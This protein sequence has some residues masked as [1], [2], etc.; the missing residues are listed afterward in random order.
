LVDL[1]RDSVP[2]RWKLLTKARENLLCAED[3]T[4]HQWHNAST[5]R[6]YYAVYQAGKEFVEAKGETRAKGWWEHVD[7]ANTVSLLTRGQQGSI[8]NQMRHLRELADYERVLLQ[9]GQ[10]SNEFRRAW[11]FLNFV[12]GE[13]EKRS[14]TRTTT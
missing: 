6:L 11:D 12:H 7:L 1:R 13:L 2:S 14:G 4:N 8:L 3:A 9:S 5:S 10:L